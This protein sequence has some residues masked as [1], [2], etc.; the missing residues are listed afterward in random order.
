[1]PALLASLAALTARDSDTSRDPRL[2]ILDRLKELGSAE[3]APALAAYVKDADPRIAESAA[4]LMAAWTGTSVAPD[5]H[6]RARARLA[7]GDAELAAL[8]KTTVRVTMKGLGTFEMRMLPDLAPVSWAHFVDLARQGYYTGLTFHR[9]I[10]NFLIQ[11]GSPGANELV[12]ANRFIRDEV[13]RTSQT[14]GT[15]GTSTRGLDT[16][17]AQFY[18]NLVDT[19]RLDHEYTIFAMVTRGMDVVD[20]ILEGDTIEKVEVVR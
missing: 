9:V 8:S 4:R 19:P 12:G 10:A 16:G 2:A 14:R 5:P 1:V 17:D 7:L 6:P 15:V 18:I 20:G 11:G 3:Q 13:G